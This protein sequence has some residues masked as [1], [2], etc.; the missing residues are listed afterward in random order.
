MMDWRNHSGDHRP[1]KKSFDPSVHG[2][3]LRKTARLQQLRYAALAAEF[4]SFRRVG[5]MVGKNSSQVSRKIADLE[6]H[7]GVSLFERGAFGVRP[8]V[9]GSQFIVS[10][11]AA[12]DQI[13]EAI[14]VAGAA[15]RAETGILRLGIILTIA[16]GALRRL[17]EAYADQHADI[18]LVLVDGGRSGHLAAIRAHTLDVAFL[19]GDV[20][21]DGFD[22][23]VFWREQVHLAISHT[24]RLAEQD[25]I[26]W[27]D[28]AEDRFLV[29]RTEP[30]PEVRRYILRRAEAHGFVPDI[31][32]EDV[33]QETLMNLVA[34]GRGVTPVAEAWK[35]VG[36]PG[37]ILLPIG[38]DDDIV[39]FSAYWSPAND[40]P[41]LRRFLSLA[42]IEAKRNGALCAPSRTPDP[43]P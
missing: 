31:R 12:L 7:L 13:D 18:E 17:I 4:G 32:H 22:A 5:R 38:S 23:E 39:P 8:T 26:D 11:R 1:I 14:A 6:D 43:S 3:M 10:I 40:N 2:D 41:A 25:R 30:G 29:C 33:G 42:R 16:Q 28:L 20:S 19:P 24:H 15:G 36:L 37:L 9:A 35:G 34:M 21:Y 27:A